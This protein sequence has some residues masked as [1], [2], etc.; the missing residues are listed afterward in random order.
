[1]IPDSVQQ[2]GQD[3]FT[4]TD[5]MFIVQC[6]LALL[7]SSIAGRIRLSISWYNVAS[8]ATHKA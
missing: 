1:M 8:D 2:I 6:S 3:A 7:Q 4:G 5:D